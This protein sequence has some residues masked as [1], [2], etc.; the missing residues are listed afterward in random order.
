MIPTALN[1]EKVLSLARVIPVLTIRREE[2]AAP[3]ATALVG[4]GL[5]VLEVTLRTEAALVAIARI[6]AEVANAVVGAG[7]VTA[8]DEL[9]VLEDYGAMFAVSPGFDPVLAGSARSRRLPYLPGVATAS[10]IMQARRLGYSHFKFFPAEGAGGAATLRS[11]AGPFPDVRFCPTGGI[12][13]DNLAAYLELP[14]VICVAGT[15]LAGEEEIR[16]AAWDTIQQRARE[17]ARIPRQP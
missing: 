6:R 1:I 10:E 13:P 15:W 4:G 11:F 14:N 5:R 2:D 3:L 7:T 8:L 12:G 16:A 17:L 9:G